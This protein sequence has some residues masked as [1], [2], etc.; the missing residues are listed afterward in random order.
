[1]L[2]SQCYLH[3]LVIIKDFYLQC[4][5]KIG[6]ITLVEAL[7]VDWNWHSTEAIVSSRGWGPVLRSPL[8]PG[9]LLERSKGSRGEEASQANAGVL[10]SYQVLLRKETCKIPLRNLRAILMVKRKEKIFKHCPEGR[11]LG[12]KGPE[13]GFKL[14]HNHTKGRKEDE[15]PDRT[16]HWVLSY[17][18]GLPWIG[19]GSPQWSQKE[20]LL[21]SGELITPWLF[22]E[23]WASLNSGPGAQIVPLPNT[24]FSVVLERARV[25]I[26]TKEG[27]KRSLQVGG[28]NWSA[29]NTF[30]WGTVEMEVS[31]IT[32]RLNWERFSVKRHR[33]AFFS[34]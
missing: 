10:C 1:M 6:R 14:K 18:M 4:R 16:L 21:S 13:K 11:G 34:E 27:P 30:L 15:D 33:S 2:S 19:K 25:Q 9:A 31:G 17:N 23:A 24:A 5:I 28:I 12:S 20:R 29:I 26:L 8:S 22:P 3:V 7:P 32:T